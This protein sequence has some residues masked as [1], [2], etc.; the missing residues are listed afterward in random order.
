MIENELLHKGSIANGVHP[1][2]LC[3]RRLSEQILAHCL[4]QVVCGSS[5][6]PATLQEPHLRLG[7]LVKDSPC[8]FTR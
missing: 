1:F 8:R 4:V 3:I 6:L 5:C 2:D 7:E